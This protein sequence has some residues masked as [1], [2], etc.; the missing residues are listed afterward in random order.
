MS[1]QEN[2]FFDRGFVIT[3]DVCAYLTGFFARNDRDFWDDDMRKTALRPD[4]FDLVERNVIDELGK[5]FY[6]AAWLEERLWED[7]VTVVHCCN[8]DGEA[9]T[10][11]EMLSGKKLDPLEVRFENDFLLMIPLT[12]APELFKQ[13]Y[14]DAEEVIQEIKDTLAPYKDAFPDAFDV[15][16]YICEV[17]GT[18]FS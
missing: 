5:D 3:P 11:S 10:I 4:F 16:R 15:A 13:V 12:R 1:M 7:S 8:F 2:A 14:R 6:D 18:D 9:R 17:K